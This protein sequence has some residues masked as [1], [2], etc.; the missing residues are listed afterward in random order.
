MALFIRDSFWLYWGAVVMSEL[1]VKI[2]KDIL[3]LKRFQSVQDSF[4]C[5]SLHLWQTCNRIW[6]FDFIYGCQVKCISSAFDKMHCFKAA[7]QSMLNKQTI[8]C[9]R[10]S[11]KHLLLTSR[12]SPGFKKAK[13]LKWISVQTFSIL[14]ESSVFLTSTNMSNDSLEVYDYR[15]GSWIWSTVGRNDFS[16]IYRMTQKVSDWN[17]FS[18]T[19]RSCVFTQR[20]HQG[21]ARG[22][23]DGK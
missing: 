10:R 18:S 17:R 12:L 8:K 14:S 23:V 9:K 11:C 22:E 2:R 16:R 6:Y 1:S 7:V 21:P 5:G 13:A 15:M 3:T 19:A 20:L 4:F